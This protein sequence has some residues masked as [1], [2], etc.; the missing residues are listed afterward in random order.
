M[1]V[2]VRRKPTKNILNQNWESVVNVWNKNLPKYWNKLW[3]QKDEHL[4]NIASPNDVKENIYKLM[5][6]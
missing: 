6:F 1:L 4:S 5:H 3:P 2:R